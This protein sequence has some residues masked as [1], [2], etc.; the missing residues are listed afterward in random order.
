MGKVS[1]TM[2]VVLIFH[3]L[4]IHYYHRED[5]AKN[6]RKHKYG[7]HTLDFTTYVVFALS[8]QVLNLIMFL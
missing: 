3:E 2:T 1:E 4:P 7:R 8:K 6:K 5:M